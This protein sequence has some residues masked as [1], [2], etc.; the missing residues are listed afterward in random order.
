MPRIFPAAVDEMLRRAQ[1]ATIFFEPIAELYPLDRRGL[2]SRMR[3]RELDRL[4]GLTKYLRAQ[5]SNIVR[6]TRMGVA[7]NPLNETVELH[8]AKAA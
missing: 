2:L 3:A 1:S 6:A 7:T 5:G 4:H 8:V